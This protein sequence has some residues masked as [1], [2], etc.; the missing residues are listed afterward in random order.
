[1]NKLTVSTPSLLCL[2][3]LVSCALQLYPHSEEAELNELREATGLDAEY[4]SFEGFR[5]GT[6]PR[7]FESRT[8]AP[9]KPSR[10]EDPAIPVQCWIETGYGTQNAC[11]YCHTDYLALKKHGNA[12]PLG[13]DQVLFS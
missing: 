12:F 9:Y 7:E 2:C 11:K 3:L 1:M 8:G 6:V 13:E 10:N 5:K 4:I